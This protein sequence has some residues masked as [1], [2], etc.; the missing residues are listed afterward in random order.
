MNPNSV[1][2]RVWHARNT[3]RWPYNTQQVTRNTQHAHTHTHT[4]ILRVH[5]SDPLFFPE[6]RTHNG[7]DASG[8]V[9]A[10]DG[11]YSPA[12]IGDRGG[13]TPVP[14]LFALRRQSDQSRVPYRK[15]Q[16]RVRIL[17]HCPYGKS[18]SRRRP[19]TLSTD[20]GDFTAAY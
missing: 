7:P 1:P 11:G 19:A 9:R 6:A 3:T 20:F 16:R 10:K 4:R 13:F 17:S 2:L 8:F 18:S 5:T 15:P 14:G 12:G